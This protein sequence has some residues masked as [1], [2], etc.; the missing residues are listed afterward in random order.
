MIKNFPDLIKPYT[1]K[2]KKFLK[3]Q[4]KKHKGNPSKRDRNQIA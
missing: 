4:V 3:A 1:Y 2:L